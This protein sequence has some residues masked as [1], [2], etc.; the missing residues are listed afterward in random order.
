MNLPGHV[1]GGERSLPLP[2][3]VRAVVAVHLA[4]DCGEAERLRER[5]P[6]HVANLSNHLPHHSKFGELDY[7][8]HMLGG[9]L[10]G[11]PACRQEG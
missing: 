1:G 9:R 10:R 2:R 8:A 7:H 11:Q 3:A 4:S 5:P 6:T